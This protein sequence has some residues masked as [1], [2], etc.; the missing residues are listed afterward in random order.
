[1]CRSPKC[2]F[3]RLSKTTSVRLPAVVP[4]PTRSQQSQR[5]DRQLADTSDDQDTAKEIGMKDLPE[6]L[7]LGVFNKDKVSTST[8]CDHVG[9][10]YCCCCCSSSSINQEAQSVSAEWSLLILSSSPWWTTASGMC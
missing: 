2:T 5:K 6:R 4:C 10:C 7:N 8:E 9:C 1:M 3:C